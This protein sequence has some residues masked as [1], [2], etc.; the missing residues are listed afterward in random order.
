MEEKQPGF[1]P[2]EHR[3]VLYNNGKAFAA[4]R[5]L[6]QL[7]DNTECSEFTVRWVMEKHVQNLQREQRKRGGAAPPSAVP[8][9]VP[10]PTLVT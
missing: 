3:Q 8:G 7:P 6:T 9:P 5:R 4:D 2:P 1:V 10:A